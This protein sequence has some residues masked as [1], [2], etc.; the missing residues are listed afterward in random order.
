MAR[1]T[2]VT[3]TLDQE[4]L[5][6][7]DRTAARLGMPKSGVVR[8]AVADYVARADRLSDSERRRMLTAF[9]DLV[10]QIAKRPAA[11]AAKEIAAIRAVRRE[12]WQRASKRGNG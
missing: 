9:D 5:D 8:E 11:A 4:T 2:K 7:I 12:G 6:R 3:Y 10:P 1:T